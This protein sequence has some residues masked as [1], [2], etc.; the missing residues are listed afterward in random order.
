MSTRRPN[1][2]TP[3][4]TTGTPTES[5]PPPR[6]TPPP[7]PKPPRPPVGSKP[8]TGTNPPASPRKTA[9]PPDNRTEL[10]V[11]RPPRLPEPSARPGR[12]SDTP[13]DMQMTKRIP[14]LAGRADPTPA[15]LPPSPGAGDAERWFEQVP[16]NPAHIAELAAEKTGGHR[17]VRH[18]SRV[19]IGEVGPGR[20]VERPWVLPTLIAAIGLTVGMI[21]GGLLFGGSAECKPCEEPGAPGLEGTPNT[22]DKAPAPRTP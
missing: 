13:S 10:A 6:D 11:P 19:P 15:P 22:I 18:S 2:L 21:L 3:A 20:W 1:D 7:L 5:E 4:E 14:R 9:A 8:L 12:R 16:T 17:K